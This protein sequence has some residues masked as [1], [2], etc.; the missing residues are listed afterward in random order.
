MTPAQLKE[1]KRLCDEAVPAPWIIERVEIVGGGTF[2][3]V[4]NEAG[5]SV[6]TTEAETTAEI[7]NHRFIAAARGAVPE[8]VAEVERLR[9]LIKHAE[10]EGDDGLNAACPWCH[11]LF[12]EW[13]QENPHTADCPAFTPEGKVK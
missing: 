10:R 4:V 11:A 9:G 5:E 3:F 13:R 2:F 8:L 6:V 1:L 12:F 7:A